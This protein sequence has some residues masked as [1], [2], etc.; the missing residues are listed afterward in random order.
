MSGPNLDLV[1]HSERMLKVHR[2]NQVHA[3]ALKRQIDNYD[4]ELRRSLGKIQEEIHDIYFNEQQPRL[5][6]MCRKSGGRPFDASYADELVEFRSAFSQK[7]LGNSLKLPKFEQWRYLRTVS[8]Q[9]LTPTKRLLREKPKTNQP[10]IRPT[11]FVNTPKI[12][13]SR[14]IFQECYRSSIDSAQDGDLFDLVSSDAG[15]EI[16]CRLFLPPIY[17]TTGNN[18]GLID[19]LQNAGEHPPSRPSTPSPDHSPLRSPSV[20]SQDDTATVVPPA[21]EKR[22]DSTDRTNLDSDCISHFMRNKIINEGIDIFTAEG[23]QDGRLSAPLISNDTD[24]TKFIKRRGQRKRA[25]TKYQDIQSK[26][27]FAELISSLKDPSQRAA[28]SRPEMVVEP[29]E[30]ASDYPKQMTEETSDEKST[31]TKMKTRKSNNKDAKQ[32]HK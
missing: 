18:G 2:K 31:A 1:S 27:S 32:K 26:M 19:Y 23:F 30:E 5:K 28:A 20:G 7:L 17:V 24:S 3:C 14:P 29:E 15:D 4:T 10:V 21:D 6:E 11:Q 8:N 12:R 13:A 9:Q 25:V 16:N 22:G